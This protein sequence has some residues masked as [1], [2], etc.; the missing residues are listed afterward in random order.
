MHTSWYI[1]NTYHREMAWYG[2]KGTRCIGRIPEF[3]SALIPNTTSSHLGDGKSELGP[4][5][6]AVHWRKQVDGTYS[7]HPGL[8]PYR[9]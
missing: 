1:E 8:Q 4:C 6:G 5:I 3:Y 9:L 7:M 2:R